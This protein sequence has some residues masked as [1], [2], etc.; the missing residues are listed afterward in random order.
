[1]LTLGFLIHDLCADR[2]ST[3]SGRP[4]TMYKKTLVRF[5]AVAKRRR[6]N[7]KTAP[8]ATLCYTIVLP[9][10]KSASGPDVGKMLI[11]KASKS[12]PSPTQ[13]HAIVLPGRTSASGP[14]F[15]R[16]LAGC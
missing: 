16:I 2:K 7:N 3:I 14:D 9:G 13:C 8:S 5:P 10:R 12:A 4:K 15:G 11:G 1:M 6:L